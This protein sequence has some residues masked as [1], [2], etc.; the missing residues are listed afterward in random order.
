MTS[1]PAS[2]TFFAM[3]FSPLSWPSSTE[4]LS[5]TLIFLPG[6]SGIDAPA[7]DPP[8]D[9]HHFSQG[10]AG[11]GGP[12]QSRHQLVVNARPLPPTRQGFAQL[13]VVAFLLELDQAFE[14]DVLHPGMDAKYRHLQILFHHV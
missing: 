8:H 2:A 1:I 9:L 11:P 13:C 3:N 14:H 6:I 7:I 12:D 4:T 10:G 5:S